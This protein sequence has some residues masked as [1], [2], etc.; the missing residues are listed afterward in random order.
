MMKFK[1]ITVAGSGVL[2]TQIAF[3]IA[4]KGFHV[5]VYDINDEAIAKAKIKMAG[6]EQTYKDEVDKAEINFDRST[7][8]LS[9]NTNLLPGLNKK[10][11]DSID[12]SKH[13]VTSTLGRI[14]YATDLKSAVV[15]TDLVIEAIPEVVKIKHDFYKQLAAVAPQKTIFT[16]NSSTLVPS[17]FAA[18][19]G[20]PSKFLALHFANE[21]WKNN[22]AEIMAHSETDPEVFKQVIEFARAIGM[23]PIPVQKEQSGYILNSILVPFLDAAEMLY[24]EGIGDPETID[25]TWMLATGAPQGPFGILDVVGI[26]TAYNIIENYAATTGNHKYDQLASLLKINFIDQG[27]LGVS[28]GEGFYHYPNPKYAEPGFL[29]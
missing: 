7:A 15:H 9:Y 5:T 18:D 1:N 27:K 13:D 25:K 19:T 12:Q 22:T 6:L 16:T 29:E 20:R 2:G 3:Q 24:L 11:S 17:M 26:T 21:I 28:S 8:G 14:D 4:F 23:V 10:V